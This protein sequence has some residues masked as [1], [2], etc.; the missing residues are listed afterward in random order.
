MPTEKNY[1]FTL[2]QLISTSSIAQYLIFKNHF[3]GAIGK[4]FNLLS[5]KAIIKAPVIYRNKCQQQASGANRKYGIINRGL[6]T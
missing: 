3:D 1:T 2:S 5:F 6:D 4:R